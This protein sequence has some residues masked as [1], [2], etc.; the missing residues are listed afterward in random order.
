MNDTTKM[1]E[2]KI[3][4]IFMNKETSFRAKDFKEIKENSEK[5]KMIKTPWIKSVI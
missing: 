3:K 4:T 5:Q 2:N 1:I